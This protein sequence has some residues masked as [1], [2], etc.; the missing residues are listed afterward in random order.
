MESLQVTVEIVDPPEGFDCLLQVGSSLQREL[1]FE[2]SWKGE[3][4]TGL[5]VVR[6]SDGRRFV[7]LVWLEPT[8]KR[9]G[10]IKLWANQIA[11]PGTTGRVLVQVPGKDSKGRP[12]CAT[13][14]GVTSNAH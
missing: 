10:R 2:I 3:N 9:Y 4:P 13:V 5:A 12:A 11:A 8:G 1:A 14:A 7:Y 6:N